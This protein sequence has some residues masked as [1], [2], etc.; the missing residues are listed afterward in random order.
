MSP[1]YLLGIDLGTTAVKALLVSA[2]GVV[3]SRATGTY[4]LETPRALWAEQDPALWWERTAA[5]VR[6][7]IQDAGVEPRSIAAVGL[8]GQM[9]GL[10]LLG[11]GREVLRPAILWNDQRTSVECE[12]IRALVGAVRLRELTGN[13]VLPGF[14]APKLLWVARNEPE[15]FGRVQSVLLPKD[16]IR[17]RLTG[18]LATDVSDA[19]GTSLFDVRRRSWSAP[20]LEALSVP[21][22][23][24]PPVF[25]SSD[26]TGHVNE[27]A[28][29]LTGLRPGTPV[30]AGA[31]DQAAQA[32]GSGILEDGQV[33][34]TIGTSG[35]VFAPS[36]VYRT[37]P[38]GRLHAFCH[39][40]RGSWHLMGVMLAA[41]GSLRWFRD[42]LWTAEAATALQGGRDPYDALMEEAATVP[43]G[44]D[45]L[46]FLPYLCGE[47]TPHAD[48]LARGVFYGLTLRH[49]RAHMARAVIEGVSFALRD[50]LD[51]IL[52][53]GIRP[54]GVRV[55]GGGARSWL[56]RQVLADVCEQPVTAL[57]VPDAA[58]LGAAILAGVGTGLL[59]SAGAAVRSFVREAATV[60]PGPDVPRYR[61][62]R[63]VYRSL[64]PALQPLMHSPGGTPAP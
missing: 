22:R 33:S 27:E 31:G 24:L 12:R 62:A 4:P 50:S 25:E 43:A 8:T 28:A 30:V 15:F 9:H 40:V 53:L 55:S 58:A 39:A 21:G 34:I 32:A 14:T 13:D 41:G 23:W 57:D 38:A 10:V 26:V 42:V 47:R 45:G 56:W 60:A 35:V 64:Y 52:A 3:V 49:T 48:P 19:S 11:A 61:A 1:R 2:G 5:A 36:S 7:V 63:E 20:V 18:A 29:R 51:L 44:S 59:P 54:C 37:D 6:E 17:E 16:F 46:V